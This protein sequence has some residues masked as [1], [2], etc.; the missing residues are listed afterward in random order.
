MR[1]RSHTIAL[2][3]I[4]AAMLL[5]PTQVEARRGIVVI[6]HG[7]TVKEIGVVA[8]EHV[9]E[10]REAIGTV[11]SVGFVHEGFG[12][13]WLNIWTWNG[14]YCLYADDQY[15]ELEP[16]QAATLLGTPEQQLSSPLFYRFPPGLLVLTVIV[17]LIGV[18]KG[19]EEAVQYLNGEGVPV[20]QAQKNLVS[21]IEGI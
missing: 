21:M 6:N 16:E 18:A 3:A 12:L 5:I 20:D 10:V 15:W 8:D 7:E 1:T 14:R 9:A 13:F 19:F 4:M 11:P 2:L 17:I